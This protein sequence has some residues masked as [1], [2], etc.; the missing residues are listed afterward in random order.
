MTVAVERGERALEVAECRGIG[1]DKRIGMDFLQA[2]I[3]L[4]I[5]RRMAR[6]GAKRER[7]CDEERGS[8]DH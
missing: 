4:G 6:C 1:L 3:G 5:T 8:S 2:G 7:N